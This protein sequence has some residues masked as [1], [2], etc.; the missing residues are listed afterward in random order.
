MDNSSVPSLQQQ[1][2]LVS[3]NPIPRSVKDRALQTLPQGL[4]YCVWMERDVG[5]AGMTMRKGI[6]ASQEFRAGVWFGPFE[7]S[8]VLP[9]AGRVQGQDM[10]EIH[11]S[12][13]LCHYLDSSDEEV[14]NWMGYVSCCK[15][16]STNTNLL[17]YQHQGA[18]YYHSFAVINPGE[19]LVVCLQHF[20]LEEGPSGLQDQPHM[21]SVCRCAHL[22]QT[23][24]AVRYHH[25]ELPR[26][27]L[28]RQAKVAASPAT[29]ATKRLALNSKIDKLR[30]K[31]KSETDK[32]YSS[33]S[34]RAF[35]FKTLP[36]R[37]TS[38]S[39]SSYDS[40]SSCGANEQ[41]DQQETDP[42]P[43][44]RRKCSKT[45][46]EPSTVGDSSSDPA[47]DS[48]PC[49]ESPVLPY[50]PAKMQRTSRPSTVDSRNSTSKAEDSLN[51]PSR[52]DRKAVPS[53]AGL[54]STPSS[55]VCPRTTE[56][57]AGTS[58]P[59]VTDSPDTSTAEGA[60]ETSSQAQ[61]TKPYYGKMVLES[62]FLK[63]KCK[64]LLTR[65]E[66][67]LP[68]RRFFCLY[69]GWRFRDLY[70]FIKHKRRHMKR[71]RRVKGSG[72]CKEMGSVDGNTLKLNKDSSLFVCSVCNR[73]FKEIHK[74]K[75]H[76]RS[77]TN[78]TC[79]FCGRMFGSSTARIVHERVHIG[80]CPY[81]CDECPKAFHTSYMRTRHKQQCH[82]NEW[83]YKCKFCNKKFKVRNAMTTHMKTH[84][85]EK[86]LPCPVCGK[87]FGLPRDLLRHVKT[88]TDE[89]PFQ[90][91]YCQ[92]RYKQK[93]TLT[94]H[95]QKHFTGD[96][97]CQYCP[98]KFRTMQA[99][100]RHE[101]VHTG[102]KPVFKR[103]EKPFPCRYCD[104]VF[105][106]NVKRKVHERVHT[107]ELPFQCELCERAYS[108]KKGLESHMRTHS[109]ERPYPCHV[110]GKSF[111]ERNTLKCHMRIH[112]GVRPFK[113]EQCDKTF[114]VSDALKKHRR[115][116][117]DERA[118]KCQQCEKAFKQLSALRKHERWHL[119][120]RPHICDVCGRDFV[121]RYRLRIHQ[122]IHLEV[123][124][125]KCNMCDK[126]FTEACRLKRH[127]RE[128]E[129]R[130][131]FGCETCGKKF[132]FKDQL[133]THI[134]THS[135]ERPFQCQSCPKCFKNSSALHRHKRVHSDQTFN[136]PV[137]NKAFKFMKSLRKHA[138][139]HIG[140]DLMS[141]AMTSSLADL[142]GIIPQNSESTTGNEASILVSETQL[143]SSN[144]G[145]TETAMY[146]NH[147][148]HHSTGRQADMDRMYP[149]SLGMYP[150][151]S[152]ASESDQSTIIDEK[153]PDP[154]S[155]KGLLPI[156]PLT[157]VKV[158]RFSEDK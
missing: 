136:C 41:A 43:S 105:P 45:K 7:G 142:C 135:E 52:G 98:L 4:R 102:V 81:P 50:I 147:F 128:H 31:L 77:H 113:C 71:Y 68:N 121:D 55:L 115:S 1:D 155:P 67:L 61:E 59:V 33:A 49:T 51:S 99:H 57:C 66:K 93:S 106:R 117:S 139:Q 84:T 56:M 119:G 47:H 53:L 30:Q 40:T 75:V 76:E 94:T 137:C 144:D 16:A 14:A 90:C 114:R 35:N 20:K 21:C 28:S 91:E 5:G 109:D 133:E 152:Q 65:I 134:K 19:E 138:L 38:G 54:L 80:E 149:K 8:V 148:T 127:L 86:N 118:Y 129:N 131:E 101:S 34:V 58:A 17:A 63:E 29:A 110:C 120:L 151:E 107:G 83:L 46:D 132:N 158:E 111:K 62:A 6:V 82:T 141:Y 18:I 125:H 100:A 104:R 9:S 44:C 3:S 72:V 36:D 39:S 123:R 37:F 25:A 88:H 108:S 24:P 154:E 153:E 87:H 96:F 97:T 116:H 74:M 48:E 150:D 70:H 79:H 27:K 140:K 157:A 89:R 95:I 146:T 32:D 12:G 60:G 103:V 130:R 126:S 2:L 85:Q 69:C 156:S 26:R 78:H 11:C 124:P 122:S 13:K 15:E 42:P 145:S 73:S 143:D 23:L 10:W 112:T 64:T 22:S 92:K